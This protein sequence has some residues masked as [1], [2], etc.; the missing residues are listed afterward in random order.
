MH[1]IS[2]VPAEARSRMGRFKKYKKT[3]STP[4]I[5]LRRSQ[6]E[7]IWPSVFSQ[8]F[9]TVSRNNQLAKEPHFKRIQRWQFWSPNYLGVAQLACFVLKLQ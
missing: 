2:R 1:D 6:F 4:K 9:I 7:D 8:L 5:V 3:M